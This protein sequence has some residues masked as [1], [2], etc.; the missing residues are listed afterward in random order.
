M[1]QSD[2]V[3]SF[4]EL[5]PASEISAPPLMTQGLTVRFGGLTAL[6]D[7]TFTMERNELMSIV[8]QNGAGKSTTL[9]AISGLVPST[10]E[11]HVELDGVVIS[12]QR[13]WRRGTAGLG[14]GFQDPPFIEDATVR[15]NLLVGAH[16]LFQGSPV[17]RLLR[18]RAIRA[19]EELLRA[20]ADLLLELIGLRDQASEATGELPYGLRK[21]V[22]VARSLMSSPSLLLLDEPTSG[23]DRS[24][25][26]VVKDLLLLIRESDRLTVLMVEHHMSLVRDVSDRVLVLDAGSIVTIAA[27]EVALEGPPS[28]PS[29]AEVKELS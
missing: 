25:Q 20:R 22:D 28:D 16:R 23:L 4:R 21:L 27:P 19:E 2:S 7:V 24:E 13:A 9:N 18:P 12:G 10:R 1:N 3:H 29:T 14:R 26:E 5:F 17:S 8:G 6:N 11:S 15:E